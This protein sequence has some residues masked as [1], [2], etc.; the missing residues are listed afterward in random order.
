[1]VT[2][3]LARATLL[4]A[5]TLS[6]LATAT[7]AFAADT[8]QKYLRN[9]ISF[10][11]VDQPN[12]LAVAPEILDNIGITQGTERGTFWAS[13]Q[14]PKLQGMVRAL[15]RE[16]G[17]GGDSNLQYVPARIIGV[18]DKPVVILLINDTAAALTSAAFSQWEACDDGAG[19][20]WPCAYN[21][22]TMDDSRAECAKSLGKAAPARR[23]AWGG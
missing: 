16:P 12:N 1:M 22:A 20:A 5:L 11:Y 3:S 19:H 13:S 4:G 14:V 21:M 6:L 23:D 10:R 9:K 17:K 8:D 15:L 7:S 18:L 2:T